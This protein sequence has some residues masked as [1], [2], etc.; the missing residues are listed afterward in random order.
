MDSA[1]LYRNRITKNVEPTSEKPLSFIS[2]FSAYKKAHDKDV[3]KASEFADAI[4]EVYPSE[5]G[6]SI[7]L[8]FRS[9]D[10][11]P[12]VQSSPAKL[13]ETPPTADTSGPV[14]A[15]EPGPTGQ[16]VKETPLRSS[17]TRRSLPWVSSTQNTPNL[18][19][20]IGVNVTPASTVPVAYK[21]TPQ[22]SPTQRAVANN[23]DIGKATDQLGERMPSV[24]A[25]TTYT[26][27]R[28]PAQALTPNIGHSGL[29]NQPHRPVIQASDNVLK[30][31]QT[32]TLTTSVPPHRGPVQEP[33][34][35][36]MDLD[37]TGRKEPS[38][39]V[40]AGFVKA[41]RALEPGGAFAKKQ[42]ATMA[43]EKR[44]APRL[45]VVSWKL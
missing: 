40:F 42:T 11:T 15:S 28:P 5:I 14:A 44:K 24:H 13:Q 41:Y 43:K 38:V 33:P 12:H 35:E 19:A 1:D 18:G 30:A 39:G 6:E 25:N 45:D 27:P 29:L 8:K 17:Q 32:R 23:R 21:A 2:V 26:T 10:A 3:V 7:K 20:R 4:E 16:A 9:S 22:I 36:S 37:E 34:V 31:G